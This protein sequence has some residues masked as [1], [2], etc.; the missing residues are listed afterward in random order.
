MT[1]RVLLVDLDDHGFLH[2]FERIARAFFTE[3]GSSGTLNF[4]SFVTLWNKMMVDGV[5]VMFGQWRGDRLIGVLG[6]VLAPNLFTGGVLASE[7]FW[8]VLPEHRNQGTRLLFAFVNWAKTVRV[9]QLLMGHLHFAVSER[10]STT[11]SRLGFKKLE[12]MYS[13]EIT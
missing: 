4:G 3:S 13:M 9:D 11:Y 8:Y 6:G 1:R 12:T 7:L 10:V 2:D 5:A